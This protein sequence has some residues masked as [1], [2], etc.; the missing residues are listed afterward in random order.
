MEDFQRNIMTELE[1]VDKC[2]SMN[3]EV[4]DTDYLLINQ[5]STSGQNQDQFEKMLLKLQGSTQCGVM[6][7]IN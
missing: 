1:K 7:I 4:I 3:D 5:P 6:F 2:I